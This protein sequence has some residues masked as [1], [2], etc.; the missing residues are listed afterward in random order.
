MK[1]RNNFNKEIQ[2]NNKNY[3]LDNPIKKSDV[4]RKKISGKYEYEKFYLIDFLDIKDN[5]YV[6]S[7]F[8]R[9]FSLISNRELK[10]NKEI[11]RNNYSCII[12]KCNDGTSCKFPVHT[13]VARAF[14]PKTASD[15]KQNRVYVHHK[16]WDNDYNYYWNLEWR[17]PMEI[18]MIGR[19]QNSKEI[20]EEDVVKVVCKLLEA[21]NTIVDIFDIIK[22]KLSKDKISKIKNKAIYTHIS[23]DYRF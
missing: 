3:L 13:L 6:I 20:E 9:I 10:P 2:L 12:L 18:I 19:I 14:I 1:C 22:G 5:S 7:S 8:G 21:N 23:S 11:K 17:S 4:K 16:N 15:K